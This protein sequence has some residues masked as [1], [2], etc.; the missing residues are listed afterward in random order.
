MTGKSPA[1]AEPEPIQSNDRGPEF[2]AADVARNLFGVYLLAYDPES[3]NIPADV[4]GAY[5]R[6]DAV[7]GAIA[8]AGLLLG[9]NLAQLITEVHSLRQESALREHVLAD[10]LRDVLGELRIM[11][12]EFDEDAINEL[13]KQSGA[14]EVAGA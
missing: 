4:T 3:R 14:G 2:N 11:N 8:A 1:G 13:A 5:N 12:S 10:L 7:E 9:T 6:G